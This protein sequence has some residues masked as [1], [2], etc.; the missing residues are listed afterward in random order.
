MSTNNSTNTSNPV[1]V[2]DGGTGKTTFTPYSVIC[3]GVT[4]S[5]AL[6]NVNST[7]SVNQ[8]LTSNGPTLLPTWKTAAGSLV[9]IAT[10]SIPSNS[11]GVVFS[12]TEFNTALYTNYMVTFTDVT[13]GTSST[14]LYG[15]QW[16][17]DGVVWSTT[18]QGGRLTNNYNSNTLTNANST[19]IG[20][21]T[22]TIVTGSIAFSG[23]LNIFVGPTNIT[24]TGQFF[25]NEAIPVNTQCVGQRASA[26]INTF[27][28]ILTGTLTP[29]FDLR[30]INSGN[31]SLYGYT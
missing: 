24:W 16:S 1:S 19:N 26:G 23:Y 5:S 25:T 31:V 21:L 15:L 4:S 10:K 28:I 14:G 13:N 20:I 17:T 12:N 8:V 11:T 30:T 27:R 18:T 7:G 29:T 2:I 6:Q 3:G 22:N 9:L